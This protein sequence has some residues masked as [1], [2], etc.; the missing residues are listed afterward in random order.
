M[1]KTN[2]LGIEGVIGLQ[3]ALKMAGVKQMLL[4]L[5]KVP[6]K[7]TKELTRFGFTAW[8][9]QSINNATNG[10]KLKQT[11]SSEE[12]V[13]L[14][15]FHS[16]F[17]TQLYCYYCRVVA[18]HTCTSGSSCIGPGIFAAFHLHV[19]KADNIVPKTHIPLIPKRPKLADPEA[20]NYLAC[21]QHGYNKQL[22]HV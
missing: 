1:A 9:R 21:Y 11:G 12:I 13:S 5:W 19:T 18:S 2:Q 4:S 10:G 16:F 8:R 17:G 20:G 6:D 7:E 22:P 3:R 15:I 14:I